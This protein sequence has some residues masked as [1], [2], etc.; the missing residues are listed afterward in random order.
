MRDPVCGMLVKDKTFKVVKGKKEYFFCSDYC[1]EKFLQDKISCARNQGSFFQN[2]LFILTTATVFL[3]TA[4]LFFE[5]LIPFQKKF[6][7]YFKALWWAVLLGIFLGGLIDYYIPREYI[8]KILSRKRSSIFSAVFLGF[9]SSFCSHGILALALELY[10]KGAAIPAVVS[11][12]LA[13]PWANFTLTIM[14]ISLFGLKGLW[15]ILGAVCVAINTGF[16]FI[17]LERKGLI[18]KNKHS[19]DLAADFSI[20]KDIGKRFKNYQ[21]SVNNLFGDLKGIFKGMVI[22]GQMLLWWLLLGVLLTSLVGAYFPEHLF[23]RFMG[24]TL[25]GLIVTLLFATVIEVCSEGSS[26]LAFEIYQ[27]TR[28]LGNSFVFLMAGV[29]TDY[30]ELGLLWFNIGRRTAIWLV[31]VSVPQVLILGYLFN[32]FLH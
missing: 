22:L 14:L 20:L 27:K 10:R 12:L 7:S 32:I 23:Y 4:S 18:E 6:F 17:L 2:K 19:L 26:P 29:V 15:I 13:T 24:P 21:L 5:M 1:R 31:L 9:L 30:T 16:I 3:L 8:V 11:F 25:L 28:A